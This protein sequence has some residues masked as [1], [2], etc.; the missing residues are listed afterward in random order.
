MSTTRSLA[1]TSLSLLNLT[2]ALTLRL[3][4]LTYCLFNPGDQGMSA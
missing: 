1:E 2:P 3:L 4:F